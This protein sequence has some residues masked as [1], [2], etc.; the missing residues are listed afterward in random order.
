MS[1][2]PPRSPRLVETVSDTARWVAA[3]RA[4][5]S[6]RADAHFHDPL[7]A[8]LAGERGAAIAAKAPTMARGGWAIVARTHAI[9]DLIDASLRQG[10]DR[11]LCLAAGL[12]ARPYRLQLP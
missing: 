12:D 11:V 1:E 8:L 10:C 9:D 6:A 4:V 5:E 7:A 2:S 3:H